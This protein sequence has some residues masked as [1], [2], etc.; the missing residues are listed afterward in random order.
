MAKTS[1]SALLWALAAA[2]GSALIAPS[3][4]QRATH[5]DGADAQ[6]SL[7]LTHGRLG[8]RRSQGAGRA[9]TRH[10]TGGSSIRDAER[11]THVAG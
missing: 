9:E 10:E 5:E 8:E 4:R 1:A 11:V 7:P 2:R 3:R 6:D